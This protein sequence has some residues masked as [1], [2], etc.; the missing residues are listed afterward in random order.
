MP[1]TPDIARETAKIRAEFAI[2]TPD[3]VQLATARVNGIDYFLT[4]DKGLKLFSPLRIMV[5]DDFV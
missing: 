4:N 2:K 3:A 1:L 5:L